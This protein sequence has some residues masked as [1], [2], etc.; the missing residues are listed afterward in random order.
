[1]L[2]TLSL[3]TKDHLRVYEL[4]SGY[5][6][7]SKYETIGALTWFHHMSGC[8]PAQPSQLQTARSCRRTLSEKWGENCY[9]SIWQRRS[10]YG[11][12]RHLQ[13][14]FSTASKIRSITSSSSTSLT[15]SKAST[16]YLLA[17]LREKY[18]FAC[19]FGANCVRRMFIIMLLI[20]PK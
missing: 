17:S 16:R 12:C 8:S 15:D 14:C 19:L 7:R 2:K 5:D 6:T 11:I 13:G 9:R 18:Q 1:M 10:G 4:Y 3:E 20:Q